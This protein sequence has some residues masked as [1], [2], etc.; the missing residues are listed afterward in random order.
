MANSVW[1]KRF[2]GVECP[3]CIVQP[4]K[5]RLFYEPFDYA[6]NVIAAEFADSPIGLAHVLQPSQVYHITPLIPSTLTYDSRVCVLDPLWK[7]MLYMYNV[8]TS[9][10]IASMANGAGKLC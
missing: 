1:C 5:S 2:D 3:P 8:Y 7:L 9:F 4:L 10:V 6:H